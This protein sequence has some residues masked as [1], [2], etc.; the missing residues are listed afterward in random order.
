MSK[1]FFAGLRDE[2]LDGE[3]PPRAAAPPS[4]APPRTPESCLRELPRA[5]RPPAAD[6]LPTRLV[7]RPARCSSRSS[8]SSSYSSS[9]STAA[10]VASSLATALLRKLSAAWRALMVPEKLWLARS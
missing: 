4:A 9:H 2:K 8:S 6:R 7:R 3:L 5:V 1:S 10:W